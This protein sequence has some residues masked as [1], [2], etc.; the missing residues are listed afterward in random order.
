MDDVLMARKFLLG[1]TLPALLVGFGIYQFLSPVN[2][3]V[4]ASPG[5]LASYRIR[6]FFYTPQERAYLAEFR[7]PIDFYGIALDEN[8][9]PIANA[10]V[11]LSPLDNPAMYGKDSVCWEK[12]G[13]D[14]RFSLTGAHGGDLFVRVE[15]E[16]YY[17]TSDSVATFGFNPLSSID[18]PM[19][20]KDK[21]AVLRL[22]KRGIGAA[23]TSVEHARGRVPKDGKSVFVSLATGEKVPAEKGDFQV[24]CWVNDGGTKP[25]EHYEWICRITV[26]NGGLV[27][28]S[29]PF[30]FM[31]PE[32]GY[33]DADEFH[34]P[35]SPTSQQWSDI[36]KKEYFVKT[37][38]GKFARMHFEIIINRDIPFYVVE[39]YLNPTGSRY[40]EYNKGPAI[41]PW[42]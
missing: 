39:S 7:H 2:P 29:D 41:G 34:M 40:L 23:L 38:N 24:E 15:K 19:P 16:G 9:K 1:I 27:E 37:G 12:T 31:A 25:G 10:S 42:H 21:P 5:W 11:K 6:E 22:R 13:Q 20:T 8:N 14:G 28:R 30:G 4:R 32:S 33:Q 35:K 18:R 3:I 26:P 17:D 36:G